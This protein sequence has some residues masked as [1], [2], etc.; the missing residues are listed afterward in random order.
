MPKRT[1][2]VSAALLGCLELVVDVMKIIF[3]E[4][5]NG[6]ESST[7][8]YYALCECTFEHRRSLKYSRQLLLGNWAEA[9]V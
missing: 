9:L 3:L 6:D 8:R 2:Q 4:N 1:S 5:S 7:C